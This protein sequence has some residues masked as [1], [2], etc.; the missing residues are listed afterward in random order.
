[1]TV[2]G[3][4]AGPRQEIAAGSNRPVSWRRFEHVADLGKRIFIGRSV[5]RRFPGTL[6]LLAHD[7]FP[8]R[9]V[10]RRMGR[11]ELATKGEHRVHAASVVGLRGASACARDAVP[12]PR[13]RPMMPRI[14]IATTCCCYKVKCRTAYP[15]MVPS[16]RAR[17]RFCSSSATN[18]SVSFEICVRAWHAVSP[19]R[20]AASGASRTQPSWGSL[21][22]SDA[23]RARGFSDAA[24]WVHSLST[25]SCGS[26]ADFCR[27][28][29]YA[30]RY[31][32][33]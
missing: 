24:S 4:G 18:F 6:R 28:A 8:P 27:A 32:G 14:F 31:S 12:R 3:S 2:L 25:F 33:V 22:A 20:G 21:F 16:P 17:Y 9:P 7:R 19:D 13:L 15:R 5:C 29:S 11:V 26:S 23:W 30:W 10:G 1:M